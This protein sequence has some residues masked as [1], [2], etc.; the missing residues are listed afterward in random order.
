MEVVLHQSVFVGR[1]VMSTHVH[2]IHVHVV[3]IDHVTHSRVVHT[4]HRMVVHRMHHVHLRD[5]G[6]LSAEHTTR[7]K[8]RVE[9]KVA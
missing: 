9:Q 2:V 7:S 5:L 3:H 1:R 8:Y 6:S 4:V